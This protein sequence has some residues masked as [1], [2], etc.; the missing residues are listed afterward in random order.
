MAYG[1]GP[2]IGRGL[3]RGL[4]R[5]LGCGFGGGGGYGF[6]GSSPPW[7]YVGLGR[8][9]LPRHAYYYGNIAAPANWPYAYP[10]YSPPSASQG[11]AAYTA[12]MSKE[13]ELSNLKNQADAIKQ[14]LEQIDA[15]IQ[16]IEKDQVI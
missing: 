9:G 10:E 7:P 11:Y 6:R 1:F 15:R 5:G 13:D 4:R 14:E 3:G 16:E 2:G 12:P 8:G